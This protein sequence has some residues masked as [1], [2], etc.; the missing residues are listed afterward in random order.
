M[1]GADKLDGCSA[2]PFAQQAL[3]S[4]R[5]VLL[6][7]SA[8]I[9]FAVLTAIFF[10]FGIY[11]TVSLDTLKQYSVRYDDVCT[12]VGTTC[13]VELEIEEDMKGELVFYYELTKFHQNQRRYAVSRSVEQLKGEYVASEDLDT[14]SPL[15]KYLPCGL[16]A[17]TF[18]NDK[19]TFSDPRLADN[20]SEK[21]IAWKSDVDYMFAPL[22]ADYT[23]GVSTVDEVAYPGGQTNEHFIVWMRIAAL[24]T[25]VKTYMKCTDCEIAAGKYEINIKNDYPMTGFKG[26]KWIGIYENSVFGPKN[27]FFSIASFVIATVMLLCIVVTVMIRVLRPRAIGDSRLIRERIADH[28]EHGR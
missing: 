9:V 12:E 23:E 11:S 18:F 20:F 5:F 14:C 7:N 24:P 8:Y 6:P 21:G 28:R 1:K 27:S 26:Q 2:H 4:L 3:P 22:H 17:K 16:A 19:F 13:S 15:E 10:I 25:V